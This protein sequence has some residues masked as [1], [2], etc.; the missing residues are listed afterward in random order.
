MPANL[1]RK[2]NSLALSFHMNKVKTTV[3]NTA[4]YN[5]RVNKNCARQNIKP[6]CSGFFSGACSLFMLLSLLLFYTSNPE[7]LLRNFFLL[8]KGAQLSGVWFIYM[9]SVRFRM[10]PY[11]WVGFH[12]VRHEFRFFG[13][14]WLFPRQEISKTG[15]MIPL[16]KA[17]C[18]YNSIVT[19]SFFL[20]LVLYW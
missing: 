9:W 1:G 5:S 14:R 15:S 2:R 20:T 6:Y 16:P 4:W 3:K 12:W 17:L 10:S 18:Y 8:P 7:L 11:I 13:P 19:N